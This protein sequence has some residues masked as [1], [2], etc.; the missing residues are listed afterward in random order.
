MTNL[1][2][3]LREI[4]RDELDPERFRVLERKVYTSLE[5]IVGRRVAASMSTEQLDAFEVFIDADDEEG[6]H[7]F[8]EQYVPAYQ[9][10][11]EEVLDEHLFVVAAALHIGLLEA[12]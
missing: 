4:V 9:T 7:T 3:R 12:S 5:A 8:L 2:D 11:V 6:A 10:I 1:S